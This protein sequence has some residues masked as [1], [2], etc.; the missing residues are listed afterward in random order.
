MKTYKENS[1]LQASWIESLLQLLAWRE[2][3]LNPSTKMV[4]V[5]V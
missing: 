1:K 4:C 3:G 5:G 2:D